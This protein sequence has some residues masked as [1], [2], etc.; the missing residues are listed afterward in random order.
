[1]STTFRRPEAAARAAL[2]ASDIT[3]AAA[4]DVDIRA[5]FPYE[6]FEALQASGLL[7]TLIPVEFGGIG[8]S[9]SEAGAAVTGIAKACSSSGMILAMHHCQVACVVRHGYTTPLQEFVAEIAR[10][11]LLLASATAEAGVGGA[12]RQSISAVRSHDLGFQLEK[13]AS[14][15]SYGAYADGVLA[16]A[17]RNEQSPPSDQV[18]VVCRPPGLRLEQTDEWN[19][20]GMRGTCSP[21]F[22]LHATGSTE[23]ILPIPFGQIAEQTMLPISHILWSCVWLGIASAAVDR[24][25]ALVHTQARKQVDVLPREAPALADLLLSYRQLEALVHDAMSEFTRLDGSHRDGV[26]MA[27]TISMNSLKVAA[28]KLVIEIVS[29]A[30]TLCGMAGYAQGTPQSLGRQLRD[31]YSATVMINN[32]R[33][34]AD[35]AHMLAISNG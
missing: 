11:Q 16:T 29:A 34:L 6:T 18:L 15:I 23:M 9:L 1:M 27:F 2:I 3:A 20:L 33:I 24:A 4:D 32:S 8:A 26:P 10:E 25:L 35:N 28:S 22:R 7:G 13:S 5:R 17:R 19:T 21:G 30:L 12:V 14:T 31:A